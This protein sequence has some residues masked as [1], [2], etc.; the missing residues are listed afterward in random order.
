MIKV[1]D[2]LLYKEE[3]LISDGTNWFKL[4]GYPG[5]AIVLAVKDDSYY[6]LLIND[7]YYVTHISAIKKFFTNVT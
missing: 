2:V 4:D 7:W 1:G 3:T 5:T 6:C